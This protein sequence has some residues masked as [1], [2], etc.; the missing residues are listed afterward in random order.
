MISNEIK[1]Q[2]DNIAKNTLITEILITKITKQIATN[3]LNNE[4]PAIK[5]ILDERKLD[6][7]ENTAL[8]RKHRP[9]KIILAIHI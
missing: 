7:T 8:Q 4:E 2:L 6:T 9:T 5:K 3:I 1:N